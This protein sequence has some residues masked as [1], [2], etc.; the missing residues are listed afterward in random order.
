[1]TQYANAPITSKQLD[2]LASLRNA[3]VNMFGHVAG[4]RVDGVDLLQTCLAA[5]LPHPVTAAEASSQIEALKSGS[6]MPYAR[7]HKDWATAIV[8]KVAAAIGDTGERA[9]MIEVAPFGAASPANVI[10]GLTTSEYIA[11]VLS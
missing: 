5:S 7:D 1:V 4:V 2:Y 9:P 10:E 11:Q 6:L 3:K 8:A